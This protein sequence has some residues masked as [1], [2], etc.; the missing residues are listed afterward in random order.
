MKDFKRYHINSD[1]GPNLAQVGPGSMLIGYM[2]VGL[3]CYAV[4]AAMVWHMH[5]CC[6]FSL[7]DFRKGRNGCLV[8]DSLWIYWLCTTL[9]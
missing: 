7:A 2:S 1:R 9:C 8:A 5:K 4:M 3:L 6:L